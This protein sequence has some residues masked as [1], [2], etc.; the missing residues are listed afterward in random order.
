MAPPKSVDPCPPVAELVPNIE[1]EELPLVDAP[2]FPKRLP[3]LDPVFELP[4][5]PKRLFP[6][7]P[8]EAGAPNEKDMALGCEGRYQQGYPGVEKNRYNLQSVN[9]SRNNKKLKTDNQRELTAPR[10]D[11]P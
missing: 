9:Q 3:G 7:P 11:E 4:A 8:L 1:G 5:V 6:E 2:I 10:N